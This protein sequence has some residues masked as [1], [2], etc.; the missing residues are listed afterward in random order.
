MVKSVKN[1]KEVKK[2]VV[3]EVVVKEIDGIVL[4]LNHLE[5]AALAELLSNV[6]GCSWSTP[7][8]FTRGILDSLNSHGYSYKFPANKLFLTDAIYFKPKSLE[9]FTKTWGTSLGE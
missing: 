6:G 3:Q 7:N 9:E 8:K 1:I 2:Q 4:T 5:T